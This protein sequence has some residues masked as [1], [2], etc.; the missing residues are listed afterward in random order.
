MEDIYNSDDDDATYNLIQ[1]QDYFIV[2]GA[3]AG[4][5]D[6]HDADCIDAIARSWD[7]YWDRE[8]LLEALRGEEQ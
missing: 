4:I 3:R 5:V 7:F 1:A 8:S 6:I 2:R